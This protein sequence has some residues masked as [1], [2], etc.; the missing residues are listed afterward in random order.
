MYALRP[1][2]IINKY[3]ESKLGTIYSL[4]KITGETIKKK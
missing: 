3:A 1:K 4:E 2:G